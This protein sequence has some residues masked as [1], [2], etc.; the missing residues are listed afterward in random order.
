MG[1][2]AA[3]V[4]WLAIIVAS[5]VSFAIGW[6]WYGPLF[7][8]VWL[9]GSGMSAK[10]AKKMHKEGMG[11]KLLMNF[12]ATIVMVYVLA[13]LIGWIGVASAGNAIWLAIW[14]AIGF[15][16]ATTLLGDVTWKGRPWSFFWVN[17]FYWLV[18]LAVAGI[19]L[20]AM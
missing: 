4:N 1:L 19:I 7:G 12:I 15:F 5:V 10:D 3:S 6:I 16:A 2:E 8:K 18:N 11:G 14:L 9:A 17:F 20:V 13:N